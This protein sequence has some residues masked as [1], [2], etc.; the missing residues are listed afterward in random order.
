VVGQNAVQVRTQLVVD[1]AAREIYPHNFEIE[2]TCLIIPGGIQID[3]LI[4]NSGE[5]SMPIAP[6]WHPYFICPNDEKSRITSDLRA[7]HPGEIP[8]NGG[9]DFGI[10]APAKGMA[11]FQIPGLGNVRLTMNPALRHL[12]FWSQ[13]GADFVCIE[14]WT[15]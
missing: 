11:S 15:G 12:Q 13:P 10:P 8:H 14:P 2:Q 5:R 7:F 3:L 4:M 6:G 1:E 9:F